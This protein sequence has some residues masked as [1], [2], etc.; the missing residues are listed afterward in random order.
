MRE[1]F[2]RQFYSSGSWA[3]CREGYRK[4][5]GNLCENCL[6]NGMIEPA[7]EVHHKIKLTPKNINNPNVTLNWDNLEALCGKCHKAA[8]KRKRRYRID[9][10]GRLKIR[11]T[12]L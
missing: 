6:K 3:N 1:E 5:V 9:E 2:A 7:Q 12:P 8:H 4:S 11:G 10:S